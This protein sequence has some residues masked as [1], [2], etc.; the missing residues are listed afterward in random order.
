MWVQSFYESQTFDA[1]NL[2]INENRKK[3]RK[4]KHTKSPNQFICQVVK[5]VEAT[6]SDE[7]CTTVF[8]RIE[9]EKTMN[10]LNGSVA[11]LTTSTTVS[12]IANSDAANKINNN[13]TGAIDTT[14]I[15]TELNNEDRYAEHEEYSTGKQSQSNRFQAINSCRCPIFNWNTEKSSNDFETTRE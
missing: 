13:E 1:Y 5:R 9:W 14:Q 11:V 15:I 4:E 8:D 10:G 6:N 3:K 7:T 12:T 2:K